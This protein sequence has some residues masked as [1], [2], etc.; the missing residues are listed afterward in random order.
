MIRPS[1]FALSFT[2]GSICLMGA[3]AM[4]KGPA[5]YLTGLLEPKRLLLTTAYFLTLSMW[6]LGSMCCCLTDVVILRN[7]CV[8]PCFPAGSTLYSCLVLG[9]YVLVVCSSVMQVGCKARFDH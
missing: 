8:F 2:F 3:F 4:L 5:A 7:C 6:L 1:K 9:N